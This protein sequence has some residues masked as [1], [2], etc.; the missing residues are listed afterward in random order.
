LTVNYA[1][2]HSR[3][4]SF[5]IAGLVMLVIALSFSFLSISASGVTNSMTLIQ[6]VSYLS[7]YGAN[8]IALLVFVFVILVPLLMLVW[9]VVLSLCL[10]L[11]IYGDLLLPPTRWIFH[12][13]AWAMAEVFAIGVI[14][15]LVKLAAMARVE[16]GLAFWAYLA[17]VV[18]FI[19]AFSSLDRLTVWTDLTELRLGT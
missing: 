14:V 4:L 6:T 9:M 1:D 12:L 16:L 8:G 15:S 7:E 5:A 13:N 2:P 11:R 19:R 18:L 17:F 10:R 3:V